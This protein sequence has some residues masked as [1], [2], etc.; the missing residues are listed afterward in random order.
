MLT[1]R[2]LVVPYALPYFAYVGL[3][4][5]PA[6]I[7][8]REANYGL[9]LLVVGALLLWARRWFC[10]LRGPGSVPGSLAWGAVAGLAG[11]AL[12]VALLAPFVSAAEATPWTPSAFW[13]RFA[14]AGALV[15]VFEEMAMR[16]FVFRLALQW[17]QERGKGS[18]APLQAVLDG[19]SLN[20]VGP[21]EWS[22]TAVLVS[23]AVFAAGHGMAEWPAAVAYGLL[24]CVLWVRRRDLVS[25]IAAH[26]VTNAAL[27]LYVLATGQW[28]YW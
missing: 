25:C 21:G 26:A 6:D 7:L 18:P 15:P 22:W 24:M 8:G 17:G 20:D 10:P 3:A 28:Q 27:A 5:L 12:W 11:A 4:S 23:T 13:L 16:C 9:R 19:R 14:A 1:N 2:E